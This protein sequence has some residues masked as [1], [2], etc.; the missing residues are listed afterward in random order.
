MA[1]TEVVILA[2]GHGKRMESETPKALMPLM[3]R[4]LIKYILEAL[5]ISQVTDVPVIVIGQKRDHVVE[6]LGPVYRYAIQDEQ[7]GTG[8]AVRCAESLMRPEADTVVVLY[9][10]QPFITAETILRLVETRNETNAKIVM[11]TV[12]LPDFDDWRSV[13][14]G[15]SRILR[16]AEGKIIGVVETKDATEEEKEILEVNPAYFCFDKKWLFEKLP[17]LG[18]KNAQGEY[19][20][21]DLVKIAFKEGLEIPSV[22]ISPREAVGTNSK[23]D[24]AMAERVI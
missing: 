23:D 6:T 12:P 21:T 5:E 1:K 18:N 22:P 7:L 20:L 8:H 17:E 24:L 16:D 2:A 4:P 15:F 10:D 14:L 19:Y 3:G 9:A 11:A 13:F